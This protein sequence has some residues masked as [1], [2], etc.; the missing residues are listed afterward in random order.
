M[1]HFTFAGE[2]SAAPRLLESRHE[3][4]ASGDALRAAAA[5]AQ[6]EAPSIVVSVVVRPAHWFPESVHVERADGATWYM[7]A[8]PAHPLERESF[9]RWL[10][11]GCPPHPSAEKWKKRCAIVRPA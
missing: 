4:R 3:P 2:P 10:H 6:N 11:D 8:P 9:T 1:K 5:S 7:I